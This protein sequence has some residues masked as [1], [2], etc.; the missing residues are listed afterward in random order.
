MPIERRLFLGGGLAAAAIWRPFGAARAAEFRTD[1]FTLG[2]A[3]GCPRPNSVVI[4][5]R[6]TFEDAAPPADPF[7]PLATAEHPPLDV[8]WIV[9]SDESFRQPVRSGLFRATGD[10]GHS[11]HVEVEGLEPERWYFYRFRCGNAESPIGRTRTAPQKSVRQFRFAFASCQQ[12]EHGYYAAYRDMSGRD[13]D[14]VVHLGDYI[15]ERSWGTDHV[16][17]HNAGVPS[18]LFEYRNRYALYKSDPDLQKAHASFP[19]LMVWDDHEVTN[20]YSGDTAPDV[21]DPAEFR[22]RRRAAY[23]AWFEHMPVP[24]KIG[25][26]FDSHRIYDHYRFG[27]LLG[28]TLLDARQYRSPELTGKADDDRPERTILGGEQEEWLITTL[29]GVPAKWSV[30]AQQTLL[31]ER[32]VK[33]GADVEYNLDGWD[34]YREARRRLLDAIE[35]SDLAN[36]LI[37]GGDLHA[38]FAADV[39]RNFSDHAAK[40]MATEFVGGSM[41]SDGPPEASLATALAE[42]PHLKFA[43]GNHGYAM[44]NLSERAAQVDFVAVADRKTQDSR[45]SIFQSFA[46]V[47]GLPGVNRL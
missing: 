34:G 9:A 17:K 4:W 29:K 43:S 46:V 36:P 12:Y 16:R 40:P 3:S 41:T 39:K 45:S 19:W 33:P 25:A 18:L 27:D 35:A 15:Y 8:E 7:A 30:L 23:Q 32:D 24:P 11:V 2:V 10:F 6:L 31:S 47:D 21:P 44:M 38:F 42:N 26:A 22:R 14:L 37:I 13:L 1:P 28:I 20:N 5:T